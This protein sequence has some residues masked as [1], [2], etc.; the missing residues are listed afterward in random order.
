M[1]PSVPTPI[2]DETGLVIPTYM[3]VFNGYVEGEQAIFGVETNYE[4]NSPDGQ[5]VGIISQATTDINEVLQSLFNSF[6]ADFAQGNALD[7]VGG[8]KG[9]LRQNGTFSTIDISITTSAICTLIGLDFNINNVNGT[10][11]T[12]QDNAGNQ[13]ILT[14]TTT[15]LANTTT[16]LIFRAKNYGEILA[17]SNTITLPVTIVV[18]VVSVTNPAGVLTTGIPEETDTNLRVRYFQ[19]FAFT[20]QNQTD[21]V[22]SQLRNL[23]GITDVLTVQNNAPITDANG[24]PLF[25]LWTIVEGGNNTA[26]ANIIYKNIHGG[27]MRGAVSVPILAI[28][29]ITTINVKFDRPIYAPLYVK[30]NLKQTNPNFT[31]D[32]LA[33]QNY[34]ATNIIYTLGQNADSGTLTALALKAIIAVGGGGVP[35]DL[36]ISNDNITW[37]DYVTVTT[38]QHKFTLSASNIAIIIV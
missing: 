18:G 26:I 8:R 27:G 2:L 3:E 30:F 19:S 12:I 20:S 6:F 9:L 10:G 25:T 16:S 4:T 33:I 21:A 5:R 13:W 17:T 36:M 1:L 34:I 7:M 32:I 15:L 38:L 11:Y 35:L 14:S 31:F 29:N 28:N 24:T 23:T 22:Y 37:V